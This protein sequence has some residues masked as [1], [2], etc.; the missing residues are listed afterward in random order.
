MS[1]RIKA[2]TALKLG[3]P[4][5]GRVFAYRL[6]VKTGLNP[7]KRL[8]KASITGPFFRT[9]DKHPSRKNIQADIISPLMFRPF[10]WCEQL[11]LDSID[12]HRSCLTQEKIVGQSTPWYLIPDFNNSVGDIKGIWEASRFD[13]VIGYSKKISVGDEEASLAL[14]Q[15]LNDWLAHNSTYMGPN[16]KCGQEASIRVMH[17]AM[18]AK[19]LNQVNDPEPAL[20]SL[21]KVHLA[22]IAPTISYAVAQDNN[23]GTSEAVA[24]F[25]GG[26]W[27]NANGDSSG[28]KWMV[29]GRKWLENRAKRLIE[30]D[31][32]FSQYSTN[33]H[34]VM[35]DT[36]SMAEIW[37]RELSLPAFSEKL[38]VKLQAATNWLYQLTQAET[39]DVPN[40]GANDGA[41]LLQLTETDYRDFRPS[42]QLASVLFFNASAW[43]D[44]GSYDIPL[45]W[46]GLEKPLRALDEP[47][48]FHF[49][50][51]GYFGLRSLSK[52]AFAMM[53]YPKFR[54][55]P[56]QC[57]A[58]HVDFWLNGINL[59]RDG[60]TF[61]YNAGDEYI[62]YYGGVESHNTI[63]FDQRDQMPRLSRFLLGNWL[64]A[65]SVACNLNSQNCQASYTDCYGV[66]HQRELQLSDRALTIIDDVSG[67]KEAAVL[68]WRLK[69]GNWIVDGLTISDG[70][71]VIQIQTDLLVKRIDIIQG[72]E[73]RYYYHESPIPVVEIEVA[74]HGRIITEYRY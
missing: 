52:N 14:N 32:S 29:L 62:R 13:W 31:G 25:I 53:T 59:L 37:R 48:N 61:S 20:L 74:S 49:S 9:V 63:Q 21:V 71:H 57:D 54:F 17:L 10:G 43:K 23:H 69:P 4:N 3:I 1:I 15:V 72:R 70:E 28:K 38:L 19:L 64:K 27:L 35:L 46:L 50:D 58:L 60:G 67:F 26:S 30:T 51:G 5:L 24:L 45:E 55:R 33:Y 66:T 39:G 18:A 34:R 41:R 16:W 65:D 8:E 11:G 68:R 40:L 7:V 56:S 22:R 47:S 2:E 6:G 36:Y 44:E 73:S 12:W 42:V